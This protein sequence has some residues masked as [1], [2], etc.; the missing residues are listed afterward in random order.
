MAKIEGTDAGETLNGTSGDD[1][2]YGYGGNDTL[3]GGGGNDIL[4]GGNGNDN[5]AGGTGNDT[6]Y[7]DN[8]FGDFVT[9]QAGEGT[10]RVYVLTAFYVLPANVENGTVYV[11]SGV[12]LTGNTLANM[13]IGNSG[14]DT[15]SGLD[16]NDV[17]KGGAGNDT[18]IG[19]NGNDS[20]NG[21]L[22]T[23][24]MTG[25]TGNDSYYVDSLSD[26][27]TEQP[28]QGTDRVYVVTSGYALPINVENGT[29]NVTFGVTLTGNNRANILVGNIGADLLYGLD[30]ND[31]LK[32]GGGN[33]TLVGGIGNDSYYVDSLGDV[34]T[35]QAGEGT[36]R[37][38]VETSG[39]VLPDNVEHGTVAITSG[40]TLTGNGLANM[41][42]GNN[43]DD[44]FYGL[45][46]NDILRGGGG[47]DTLVGGSGN[48]VLNGQTGIDS[49]AG[50]IGNDLYY[51]DSLSDVVTELA[52]EGTDRVYAQTS[53]YVLPDNVENG[54]VNIASGA[55]LTGNSLANSL[56]GGSGNDFLYGL[57]GADTLKG[58]DGNDTLLGG[59]GKDKLIGGLGSDTI[60]GGVGI[61]TID[62][63]DHVVDTIV[64]NSV[65]DAPAPSNPEHF[66]ELEIV[67]LETGY[68]Q[69]GTV[70]QGTHDIIDLSAIDANTTIDGNQAF[71]LG[72]NSLPW[73]AGKL[74]IFGQQ[75]AAGGELG[76]AVIYADVDGG[77]PDFGIL[78]HFTF[79]THPQI[80]W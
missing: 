77:G 80:I 59:A 49:M 65:A 74:Y 21:G 4:D 19:G 47:S 72:D 16:G 61:D 60:I 78:I 50:G 67:S 23:D 3:S 15:L 34:V 39:Y 13:L 26:V 51:V 20:L 37:V 48:D 25:G 7:V 17:L 35:E 8:N 29:V 63:V 28:G 12:Q 10:D 68:Y 5:M 38:Y 79:D 27:V 11:T 46:G 31:T 18:L 62:T 22:G 55:T 9:E 54:T 33:D 1:Q 30:G 44:I 58:G 70:V 6:Y 69:D 43:G 32:G 40:V 14:S 64:Y 36:D 42:V 71:T 66:W 56:I 73:E 57:G 76:T 45:D 41:L 75:P 2:I 52:G 53:G 24:S